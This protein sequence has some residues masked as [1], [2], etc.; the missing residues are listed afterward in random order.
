MF[1][2]LIHDTL[3]KNSFMYLK[4]Y[5]LFFLYIYIYSVLNSLYLLVFKQSL[6]PPF[7]PLFWLKWPFPFQT[8]VILF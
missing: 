1:S 4:L 6:I 5:W 7:F 2:Y 8:E 3:V